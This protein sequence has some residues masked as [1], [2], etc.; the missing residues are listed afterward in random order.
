M[1]FCQALYGALN[2]EN[3]NIFLCCAA[4]REMPTIPWNIEEGVPLDRIRRVREALIK[5]LN[6]DMDKPID[7]YEKYGLPGTAKGHPCKDCRYIVEVDDDDELPSTTQLTD[8]L[9]LGAFTYCN[10]KCIYCNAQFAHPSQEP[11][12]R[13]NSSLNGRDIEQGIYK[14]VTQLFKSGAISPTCRV[15]FASGEPSISET[16]MKILTDLIKKKFSVLINTNAITFAKE[17]EEALKS[18]RAEVQV[19]LDSGDRDSYLAVKGVDRFDDVGRNID[20]YA[21]AVRGGS[22]LWIKYIL[23]SKNNSQEITQNFISFCAQHKIKNVVLATNTFEGELGIDR[24]SESIEKQTLSAFGRIAARLQFIGVDVFQEFHFLTR[25]EQEYVE[26]KYAQAVMD[27]LSYEVEDIDSVKD[28]ISNGLALARLSTDSP[29]LKNHMVEILNNAAKKS[30]GIALFSAGTHSQWI[31]HL[32]EDLGIYPVVAFD[33]NPPEKSPFSYDVVRP[34]Q[35]KKLKVDTVIIA[36][37]AY[38]LPIYSQI[39][40]NPDFND[41][42]IVDPYLTL[43]LDQ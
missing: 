34:D 16:S 1:K 33:N 6:G 11:I 17:I 3:S 12:E 18:G 39:K 14:A 26:R 23:F 35:V 43:N 2:L 8:F 36:S 38:H 4:K 28:T 25:Q 21:T 29:Q 37:N 15:I 24:K 41:I 20:R 5:G 40:K 9:N 32:M 19:S 31:N 7:A 13:R 27:E 22:T 42:R 30:N 10:A